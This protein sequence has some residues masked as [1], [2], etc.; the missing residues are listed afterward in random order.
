LAE[1]TWEA[2]RAANTDLHFG[3][4]HG[5]EVVAEVAR[6]V[7]ITL[8]PKFGLIPKV[9]THAVPN[10]RGE[11][12]SRKAIEFV[13]ATPL[14]YLERWIAANDVF[15]DDVK[16]T[17]VVQWA[18]GQ[19]SFA[20]SQP[21]YHGEPA[22]EREIEQHFLAAGWT[23]IPD[24][25]GQHDVFFNYAFQTL[26]IDTLPRNCYLKDGDLLP[27]DVILCQPDEELEAFLGLYD[28]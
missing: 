23:R 4:E 17:A 6:M 3:T 7:K 16:L 24:P 11:P 1:E 13:P 22:T 5:V 15:G 10:L 28:R 21:Q 26:A 19:V 9:L 18:D 12:G 27:F 2:F 14:E 8:P 25:A 20:I